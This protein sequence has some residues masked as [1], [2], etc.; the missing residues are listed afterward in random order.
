M[1][2]QVVRREIGACNTPMRN[3]DA[4]MLAACTALIVGIFSLLATPASAQTLDRLVDAELTDLVGTYKEFHTHP[5]LSGQEEN[6]AALLAANLRRA[7]YAV[8]EHIGKYPDGTRAYGL[9][10]ILE[11][12]P[13]PRLL[14]RTELDALPI[15]EETGLTYASHA[16]ARNAA[17]QEVGVMHA[18]G[19]DIHLAAM[20]GT[21]RALAALRSKWHGTVM[22][23]GQ[24]AEEAIGGAKAMLADHLYERFGTPDLIIALHDTNTRAA[25]RWPAQRPSMSPCAASEAMARSP[26]KAWI[27]S[28]WPASSSSGC[29]PSSAVGK[30]PGIR[31]S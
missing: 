2:T 6:T 28:S 7:G 29:R 19:H 20:I 5:E 30:I 10:G 8:T 22:L 31:P 27:P 11:N 16:T 3:R 15:V 14:I 4:S 12:G 26:R 18:C 17:G 13:G 1:R 21:A 25:L 23:I 24:P 9:A